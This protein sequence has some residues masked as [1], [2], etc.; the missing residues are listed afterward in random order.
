MAA[1]PL[2]TIVITTHDRPELVQRALRSALAQTV[3]NV[4]VL[5]VD[6]GSDPPFVSEVSDDRVH[7]IR[8]DRARGPSAARNAG[9][10]AARGAWVTFLDDDDELAPDM[11]E[12]SVGAAMGSELP[13]PV[14]VMSSVVV[15]DGEGTQLATHH[16]STFTRGEHYLFEGRGGAGRVANSIVAPTEV[17][18]AIGGFDE[19]L[20]AFQHDDFGLRLNAAASILGVDDPLYRMSTH[21][22]TRVS[23]GLDSI[24]KDM[25]RTLAKHADLFRRH[26]ATHASYMA[27]LGLYHLKAG[28]W[29]PAVR[30]ATRA[31][32]RDP[33]QP[34]VWRYGIATAGGPT[35]LDFAR[36][37]RTLVTSARHRLR[38]PPKGFAWSPL[39]KRRI[40][41]Y[42]RRALDYGRAVVALPLSRT[43]LALMR[44]R[45]VNLEADARRQVLMLSVYRRRNADVLGTLVTEA[46]RRD[47]DV[48]LWALDC[49]EPTLASWTAGVGPGSKLP[50]LN[51][52]ARTADLARFEWLV[53]VDDDFRIRQGS[54]SLLLSVA[55]HAR[56]DLVQPAHTERSHR[57]F[58]ITT[59]RPL[60]IARWTSFVEAGPAF[61]VRRPWISEVLPFAEDHE[62]GWGVELE[63][64]ELGRRGAR[65][66]IVDA[67]AVQ[68][69]H[70]AG[71]EYGVTDEADR[72]RHLLRHRGLDSIRDIQRTVATWRP[73]QTEAPWTST[74]RSRIA[75]TPGRLPPSF[76]R[77]ERDPGPV[78]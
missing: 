72:L 76:P 24:T 17:V 19:Q 45:L 70:P 12:R 9:L 62:M 26:P 75:G 52:L 63:W 69:L 67:T 56:L 14:A 18:R 55:E 49:A 51:A 35:G 15:I 38:R 33:G 54:L 5:V 41:K 58:A 44:R 25:E 1:D 32:V 74:N 68:H 13:A 21:S 43:G 47:W 77:A 50:L 61:A 53:V 3:E 10:A 66:G 6:D 27:T 78:Q 71:R 11:V 64:F 59:R 20:A 34:K 30:W 4:E 37:V 73:W 40:H 2:A 28:R 65:L 42:S 48:R 31:V 23:S 36:R 39:T 46:R 16:P 29:G 60:T 7:S 8:R 57:T 22:Q